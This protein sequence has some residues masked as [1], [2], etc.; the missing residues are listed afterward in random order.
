MCQG[1]AVACVTD[2]FFV[3]WARAPFFD[4]MDA[5]S[6][7]LLCLGKCCLLGHH[8]SWYHAEPSGQSTAI[9]GKEYLQTKVAP[10]TSLC[11]ST[12]VLLILMVQDILDDTVQGKGNSL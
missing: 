9:G 5:L 12:K 1:E 8:C 11:G 10:N 7:N 2:S 6:C 3:L 4:L